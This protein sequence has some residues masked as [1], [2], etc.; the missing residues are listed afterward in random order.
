MPTATVYA[1]QF[2]YKEASC[3]IDMQVE[4]AKTF[5]VSQG[6]EH[7]IY[8]IDK[9]Y[10]GKDTDRPGFR[11]ILKGSFMKST[12]LKII[13][14][15]LMCILF[16]GC[17][18]MNDRVDENNDNLN[19]E[20]YGSGDTT[21]WYS[22]YSLTT[23]KISIYNSA[24][25]CLAELTDQLAIESISS[26][27]S[28]DQWEKVP[29]KKQYGAEP[30]YYIDFNNGTVISMLA[31]VAYGSVGTEIKKDNNGICGITDNRGHF[32][33]TDE[34]LECVQTILSQ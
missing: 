5:C 19:N 17:N 18:I 6:W 10:S 14:L 12:I 15:F 9:G 7:I 21:E 33:M 26:A 31:E 22:E 24:G 29:L 11:N 25:Q 2:F 4:R 20:S 30:D 34:F 13:S 23:E 3:S 8:D 27:V 1:R 16:G 32:H 28:F